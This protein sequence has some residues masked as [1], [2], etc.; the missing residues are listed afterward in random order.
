MNIDEFKSSMEKE[1]DSL[2]KSSGTRSR[3]FL[4]WFLM[5]YFRIEEDIAEYY[6]CDNPHD[7]GIDGIY[8][9]ELTNEIFIFQSKCS[10]VAG[11]N[12][13]D[14]DLRNF[15]GVRA[16]FQSPANIQSLDKSMAN[17]E[18]KTI[19]SNLGLLDKISQ[20]AAVNLVFVTNK[21]FDA[22]AIQYLGVVGTYYDAWDLNRLYNSYTYAGKDLPVSHKFEFSLDDGNIIQQST[23]GGTEL[24]AFAAKA[25]DIVLLQ[26]IQDQSLFDKNVR[27]GLGKT[28]INREI[29]ATLRSEA[30]HDNFLL[31]NNGITIVCESTNIGK[32]TLSIENYAVVNGCQTVL[33]LYE[34]KDRLDDKV[35][36][37]VRVI[38]TGADEKLGRRIT[39]YNNNQNAISPRDL[40]ANDKIQEDIQKEVKDYFDGKILYGIKRGESEEGYDVVLPNDFVAQLIASFVLKEPFTTHQKTKI[41]TEN[42]YNIFSRHINPPLIYLLWKM[43]DK[44]DGNCKDIKNVGARDY[45]TTR[46]FFM[47]LFSEIFETD[48]VGS[49]LLS[50][51]ESFYKTFQAKCDAAFYKLSKLLVLGF[52]NYVTI[53]EEG[54]EYFDYKNILRNGPMTGAMGREIIS[55]YEKSLV[56]HPEGRVSTLLTS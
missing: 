21:V 31:Y 9:D 32:D 43:Y 25:S 5:N 17:Q 26:G 18:L 29:A 28:R 13:G 15:E 12:Q 40:K 47:F 55:D 35:R 1:V 7:K 51:S 24:I 56:F 42:Y 11:S 46:F 45:K 52:N 6:I 10:E 33:T 16:W 37:L 14:Y 23:P 44:I 4:K 8:L 54:G 20:G 34:N 39:R 22:S 38:R 30:E 49:Q 19:V 48:E 41:F 27:Y 36:V 3:A 53:K 2:A 50:D